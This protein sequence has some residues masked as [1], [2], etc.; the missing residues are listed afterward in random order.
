VS[1]RMFVAAVSLAFSLLPAMLEGAQCDCTTYPF[2]PDPPC[3]NACCV[4]ILNRASPE[5]L[6]RVVGLEPA[7]ARKITEFK[8]AAVVPQSLEDY[9]RVLSQEEFASLERHLRSLTQ[10]KFGELMRD[11]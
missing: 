3:F 2:R 5:T 8:R 6:E 11:H 10:Q 7:I 4:A 9:R 1:L